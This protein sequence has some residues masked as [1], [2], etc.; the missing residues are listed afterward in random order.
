SRPGVPVGDIAPL[1]LPR[2]RLQL[3]RRARGDLGRG[4]PRAAARDR[5]LADLSVLFDALCRA[6]AHIA[7]G[8]RRLPPDDWRS[9]PEPQLA[10]DLGDDPELDSVVRFE[11]EVTLLELA[12]MLN[13]GGEWRGMAGLALRD[14]AGEIVSAPLRPL[15]HDLDA[16]PYPDRTQIERAF[17]GRR[18]THILASRGCIRTCSFCSIHMFYRA[19]PGKVVRTR[20]PVRDRKIGRAHV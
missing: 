2:A 10:A 6:R 15:I 1:R 3:Q 8:R 11:G 4:A 18:S 20:D 5:P 9:F 12:D 17:L 13:T 19:A 14:A 16:L 7:R